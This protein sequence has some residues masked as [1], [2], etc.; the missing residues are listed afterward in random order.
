MTNTL[1]VTADTL[2]YSKN[3]SNSWGH[4]H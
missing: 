3:T 1:T 2:S 4:L